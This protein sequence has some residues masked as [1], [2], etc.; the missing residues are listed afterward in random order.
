MEFAA[1]LVSLVLLVGGIVGVLYGVGLLLLT[2]LD[3]E[4]S[5]PIDKRMISLF[6][7]GPEI[8][9]RQRKLLFQI[10]V[11]FVPIS[12]LIVLAS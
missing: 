10:I 4:N 7:V 2:M 5:K 9:P 12:A 6:M 3:V 11:V 1:A 8:E